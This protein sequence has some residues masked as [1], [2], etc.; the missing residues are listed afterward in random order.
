LRTH[1][2][3]GKENKGSCVHYD[4]EQGG[5]SEDGEQIG[6]KNS[7]QRDREMHEVRVIAAVGENGVPPPQCHGA[8]DGHGEHD[9]KIFI[10]NRGE[11]GI[12]GA[13]AS[14][15]ANERAIFF[16]HEKRNQDSRHGQEDEHY[17]NTQV[18]L[19]GAQFTSA[20]EHTAG[21]Q[22]REKQR[23]PLRVV[24]PSRNERLPPRFHEGDTT[25]STISSATC[26]RSLSSTSCR[27]M[28]SRE[29]WPI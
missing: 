19:I 7:G 10:G 9:E 24:L 13:V 4:R 23:R 20:F 2:G 22:A 3:D 5:Q 8:A 15:E 14:Q 16:K 12:E 6:E 21:K 18:Q 26:A 29:D 1:D 28:R 25:T 17:A 27:K 11:V